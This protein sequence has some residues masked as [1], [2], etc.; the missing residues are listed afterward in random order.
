[1]KLTDFWV[2]KRNDFK[3]GKQGDTQ[4]EKRKKT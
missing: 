3:K 1:M 4:Q 2:K